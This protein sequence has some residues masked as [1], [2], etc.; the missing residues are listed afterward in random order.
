[1]AWLKWPRRRGRAET[2]AA[3]TG[4]RSVVEA[5]PY[6]FQVAHRRLAWMLRLSVVT[7]VGLLSAVVIQANAIGAMLPLKETQVALVRTY[8]PD[9]KLY[10]VEPI[11]EDVEGFDVLLESM[12]RRYVHLVIEIDPVTEA[13]RRDEAARMTDR[14]FWKEFRRERI[15]TEERAKALQDGLIR[16]VRI[17]DATRLASF[18]D[19]YKLAVDFVAID[20]RRGKEVGRKELR[21]YLSMT[22]RP[23][24]V[25]PEDRFS[26]PLG[27]TVLNFVLKDRQS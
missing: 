7:N 19:D 11:S 14:A 18:T 1:M 27:I 17:E 26:N 4:H 22:T 21:A 12:A 23:Q 3:K 13:E 24:S 16:T 9:D 5:D 20:E 8:G 10:Q 15:D 2:P 25:A 6:S